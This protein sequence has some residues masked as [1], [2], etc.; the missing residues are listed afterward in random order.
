MTTDEALR[1]FDQVAAT[2]LVGGLFELLRQLPVLIRP[3]SIR[4]DHE[5]QGVVASSKPGGPFLG[6]G[7]LSALHLGGLL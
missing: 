2:V 3:S 7:L 1:L 5:G 4:L 6:L